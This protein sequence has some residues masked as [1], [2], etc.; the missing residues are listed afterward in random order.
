M[1]LEIKITV[2]SEF[3]ELLMAELLDFDSFAET[4][5]GIDAYIL[6]D[7]FDENILKELQDKYKDFFTFSYQVGELE[8]KN[9]NEEW[10]KNFT[11]T[12]V[13]DQVM[14]RASFHPADPNF[15]HEIVINPQMSF[16]TGHHDTTAG[17][18]RL[19]LE[20]DF[21]GKTVLD[22]GTGTGIL[23]IMAEKLGA[24]FIYAYDIDEW[25]Y[26]N[27]LDNFKLNNSTKIEIEQG[28][29]SLIERF[30]KDF[31]ITLANINKNVLLQDIPFFQKHI[32]ENGYLVLSGFYQ[33]DI[34]DMIEC[35][36]KYGLSVENQSVSNNLWAVLV[37]KKS[38]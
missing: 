31:D 13:D 21:K 6:K 22:A 35:C 3:S 10:E 32:K 17:V 34:K 18:I 11:H 7:S 19:M 33:N 28:D 30:G 24:K 23:A 38:E 36:N 27:C 8:N 14:I 2:L 15:P 9:W 12:T 1:Y 26:N 16:G 20:I 4:D 25:S 37:L 5:Y 29:V